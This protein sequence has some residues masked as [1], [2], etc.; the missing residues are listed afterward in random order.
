MQDNSAPE[1]HF[2]SLVS[3]KLSGEASPDELAELD[4]L[5]SHHPEWALRMQLFANIW[6][7]RTRGEAENRAGLRP[8]IA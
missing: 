5:L 7:S 3:L 4:D 1:E 8:G 2:W 6:N